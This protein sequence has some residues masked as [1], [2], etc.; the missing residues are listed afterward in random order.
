MRAL[1]FLYVSFFGLGLILLVGAGKY[2]GLVLAETDE[3]SILSPQYIVGQQYTSTENDEDIKSTN[4]TSKKTSSVSPISSPDQTITWTAR[5]TTDG[6]RIDGNRGI[7]INVNNQVVTPSLEETVKEKLVN[8]SY[9]EAI[10]DGKVDASSRTNN[11]KEREMLAIN[12]SFEQEDFDKDGLTNLEE[13]VRGTDPYL[14]DTDRDGFSDGDEIKT[15]YDP[16]KFS[17]GDD[18]DKITFE[19]PRVVVEEE[20]KNFEKKRTTDERYKVETVEFVAAAASGEK[21]KIRFSGT[22]L[23]NT[24]LTIYVYSTPTV[25]TVKTDAEG[26]WSYDLDANIEDGDHEIYVA[27]TDN[28][29]KITARSEGLPFVKTAQAVSVRPAAAL[30]GAQE[31]KSPLERSRLEYF[32]IAFVAVIF[33]FGVALIIISRKRSNV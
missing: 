17:P 1:V 13:K 31:N 24:Y 20:K 12:P 11:L 29:G 4:E 18:R 22:A 16:T 28:T 19:D 27:V 3:S 30:T 9:D 15:G 23:P 5:Q 2:E 26:N 14:V 10:R 32:F 21:D 7:P 25:I 33:F 8:E 6:F